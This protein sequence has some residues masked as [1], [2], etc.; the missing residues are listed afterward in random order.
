MAAT[1]FLL[2][3]VG[4][5][6]DGPAAALVDACGAGLLVVVS[7]DMFTCT[8]SDDLNVNFN[9]SFGFVA[10]LVSFA[11]VSI[12]DWILSRGVFGVSGL[13]RLIRVVDGSIDFALATS[14][15]LTTVFGSF[16]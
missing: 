11:L 7:S 2:L 4:A 10:S 9:L 15:K 13:R 8:D 16:G 12:V 5:L 3:A 14:S 6:V 1:S